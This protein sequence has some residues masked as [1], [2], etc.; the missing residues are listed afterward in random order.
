M[1]EIELHKTAFQ[2]FWEMLSS[3][4]LTQT[5]QGPFVHMDAIEVDGLFH[6]YLK[7][8]EQMKDFVKHSVKEV[9]H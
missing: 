1:I 4:F 7:G 3:E 9:L 8:H 6:Q 2:G 5:G